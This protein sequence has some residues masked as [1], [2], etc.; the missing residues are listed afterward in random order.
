MLCG[1]M[2]FSIDPG[3]IRTLINRMGE[4]APAEVLPYHRC[5]LAAYLSSLFCPAFSSSGR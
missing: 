3:D 4:Q 1:L 5:G 2:S